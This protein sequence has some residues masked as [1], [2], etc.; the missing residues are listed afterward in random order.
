M[1]DFLTVVVPDLADT[2]LAIPG[3]GAAWA[4]IAAA[5]DP[6]AGVSGA[7]A[8][9]RGGRR[10]SS[11]DRWLWLLDWNGLS[12]GVEWIGVDDAMCG[13]ISKSNITT[14]LYEGAVMESISVRMSLYGM[15]GM[16][17]IAPRGTASASLLSWDTSSAFLEVT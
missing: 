15:Y 8:R 6:D 3:V 5:I 17:G 1:W 11:R 10:K 2:T 7:G 13:T 4:A 16:D 14:R 9:G 12:S